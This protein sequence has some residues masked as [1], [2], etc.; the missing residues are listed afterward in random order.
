MTTYDLP[1][2]EGF[3][4]VPTR[5]VPR[6]RWVVIPTDDGSRTDRE[7]GPKPLCGSHAN[8]VRENRW[9]TVNVVPM[10]PDLAAPIKARQDAKDAENE[11]TAEAARVKRFREAEA[12]HAARVN[13][14]WDALPEPYTATLIV[15]EETWRGWAEV[16]L[17][18][19]PV[20][21]PATTGW[22]TTVVVEVN[23]DGPAY[24]RIAGGSPSDM[25]PTEARLLADL[26]PVVAG[27]VED[28]NNLPAA[29]AAE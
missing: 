1:R 25:T 26:L 15:D 5:K 2:C 14:A 28:L 22:Q 3:H 7:Y 8:A 24:V 27:W 17:V 10:T 9:R 19:H 21:V 13:A 11:R 29:D 23:R 6:A 12:A 20:G 18:L 16:R 4:R